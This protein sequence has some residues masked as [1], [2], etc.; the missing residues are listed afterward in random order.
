WASPS[1]TPRC[2]A[3]TACS[4]RSRSRARTTVG[5]QRASRRWNGRGTPWPASRSR[6]ATTSARSSSAGSSPPP[7]LERSSASTRSPL[8]T[9]RS[10]GSRSRS[11]RWR[12]H[13]PR[14][15]CV[16]C[17]PGGGPR[18]AWKAWSCSSELQPRQCDA[19]LGLVLAPLVGVAA[20]ALVSF[21][22][23]EEQHLRDPLIG[24]DLGGEGGGV[25]DLERDEPLPLRLEGGHVGDDP[26]AGVG[27]L[28]DAYRQHIAR[29]AEVLDGARQRERD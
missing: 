1:G 24:V 23:R 5:S 8:R 4:S 14:G 9:S 27:A 13:R 3:A 29:D 12:P 11:V 2:T 17:A 28:S 18:S 7:S 22:R 6:T 26:A 15:T 25:R 21:V 19:R 20:L 16:R 10:P